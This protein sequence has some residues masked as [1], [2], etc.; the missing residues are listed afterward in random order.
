[1]KKDPRIEISNP[2]EQRHLAEQAR[3]TAEIRAL[4]SDSE[5]SALIAPLAGFVRG[6]ALGTPMPA[7]PPRP[8]GLAP[9]LADSWND[10]TSVLQDKESTGHQDKAFRMLV[11]Q[12]CMTLAVEP[13]HHVADWLQ[14]SRV[15][16]RVDGEVAFLDQLAPDLLR[17]HQQ[18]LLALPLHAS[19]LELIAPFGP[20]S[21][22]NVWRSYLEVFAERERAATD[23]W[24]WLEQV[25]HDA[26]H[27]LPGEPIWRQL[28]LLERLG[29][30]ALLQFIRALP[31]TL[32]R[33]V[34]L[35]NHEYQSPDEALE[36]VRLA[37]ADAGSDAPLQKEVVILLVQRAFAL[38]NRIQQNLTALSA[39]RYSQNPEEPEARERARATEEHWRERELPER[40][41][42]LAQLLLQGDH[43]DMGFRISAMALRHLFVRPNRL[44]APGPKA[45]TT[46]PIREAFVRS[47]AKSGR[48]LSDMVGTILGERP[49]EPEILSAA[50]V[51]MDEMGAFSEEERIHQAERIWTAYGER[52]Q[53]ATYFVT[54]PLEADDRQLAVALGWI[55]AKH[56]NPETAFPALLAKVRHPSEGWKA[57]FRKFLESRANVLHLL[58]VGALASGERKQR[59]QPAQALFRLVWDALHA[60]LRI[61]HNDDEPQ[62]ALAYV[63]AHLWIVEG[64]ASTGLALAAIHRMDRLEWIL[65][66]AIN[67]RNNMA[68][69]GGPDRLPLDLQE[70]IWRRFERTFPFLR[71]RAKVKPERAAHYEQLALQLTPDMQRTDGK[72][73]HL[74]KGD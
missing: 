44:S 9:E 25:E 33:E 47:C 27:C 70:A 64:P 49:T 48:P 61:P 5:W 30:P 13:G 54:W 40:A 23:R 2:W 53:S 19:P 50:L 11:E 37:L 52:L 14:V 57:D 10:L 6:L 62:S 22:P 63:W 67:L 46:S 3:A 38:W 65:D 34:V 1:M 56:S 74:P 20:L 72:A 51:V 60:W 36:M 71:R 8:P 16:A 55:L 28:R 73:A 21:E 69:H 58:I 24:A 26:A 68:P 29:G 18:E 59:G 32:L 15:L 17:Q 42:A 66:A 7:A 12:V 4:H 45:V 39:G 35:D 43:R 41:R 31:H